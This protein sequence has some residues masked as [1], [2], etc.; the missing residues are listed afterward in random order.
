MA[1]TLYRHQTAESTPDIVTAS[2][3]YSDRYP[4]L[5]MNDTRATNNHWS[6]GNN[7]GTKWLKIELE[8]AK[9]FSGK[10]GL[11]NVDQASNNFDNFVLKGS[12]NDSDWDIITSHSRTMDDTA[13]QLEDFSYTNTTTYKYYMLEFDADNSN[14][15]SIPSVDFYEDDSPRATGSIVIG[16]SAKAYI[17]PKATGSIVIGGSA[18]AYIPVPKATGSIVIGGSA[19]GYMTASEQN[20]FTFVCSIQRAVSESKFKFVCSIEQPKTSTVIKRVNV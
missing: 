15:I 1:L 20:I 13:W 7:S 12:N 10:I 8:V 2:G 4:W 6:A 17:P 19:V 18:K 11:Y 9:L 14:Y 3:Y 5:S 16:G